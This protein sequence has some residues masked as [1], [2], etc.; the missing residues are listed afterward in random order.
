MGCSSSSAQVVDEEKRP[1]SKLVE[2][3]GN[4]V[5]NGAILEDSRIIEDQV[6]LPGQTFLSEVGGP[7]TED[8]AE[9]V[10]MGLEAEEDLGS[11]EDLLAALVPEE[12]PQPEPSE[13]PAPSDE[14]AA[15]QTLVTIVE[16][17]LPLDEAGTNEPAASDAPSEVEA[18]IESTEEVLAVEPDVS[19]IQD[20]PPAPVQAKAELQE[21]SL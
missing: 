20:E 10:L 16:A 11:G 9:E 7:S 1:V 8:E 2:S 17:L 12:E 14:P 15:S 13:E 6:L 18:I 19:V 4:T 21:C 3:N 5:A